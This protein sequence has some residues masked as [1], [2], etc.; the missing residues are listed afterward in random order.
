MTT[1]LPSLASRSAQHTAAAQG[2]LNIVGALISILLTRETATAPVHVAQAATIASGAATLFATMMRQ[3]QWTPRGAA[4]VFL[5]NLVPVY[6]M[7]WLMNVVEAEVPRVWDP[8]QTYELSLLTVA[9]LAP[10][11]VWAG[12]VGL[13]GFVALAALQ[14]FSFPEA[15]RAFIPWQAPWGLVGF[16]AFSIVLLLYRLRARQI[17]RESI[18]LAEEALSLRRSERILMAVRDLMNTP[19]QTL[20]LDVELL[21]KHP[22]RIERHAARIERSLEK[23]RRLNRLLDQRTWDTPAHTDGTTLDSVEVLETALHPRK[24]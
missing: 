10:E 7:L 14:Y 20:A 4:V 6:V 21:L 8:F 5:L 17:E 19:T 13:G 2:A 16:G 24:E 11:K 18:R 23:L 12:I 3:L 1:A 15:V 22:E 9:V